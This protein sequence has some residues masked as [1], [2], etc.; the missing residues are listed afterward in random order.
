[1]YAVSFTDFCFLHIFFPIWAF[2]SLNN[3][4]IIHASPSSVLIEDNSCGSAAVRPCQMSR[5][6]NYEGSLIPCN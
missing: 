6:A 1:M 5:H 2:P 4:W 3:A